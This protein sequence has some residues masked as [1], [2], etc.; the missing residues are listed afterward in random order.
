MT[1]LFFPGSYRRYRRLRGGAL[2]GLLLLSLVCNGFQWFSGRNTGNRL[3]TALLKS[4]STVAAQR[5]TILHLQSER[6][7]LRP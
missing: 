5:E 3:S 2:A 1:K 6:R 4:D 7:G